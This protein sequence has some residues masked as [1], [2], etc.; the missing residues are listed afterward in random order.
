MAEH[1]REI[2]LNASKAANELS[3]FQHQLGEMPFSQLRQQYTQLRPGNGDGDVLA[4]AAP[5]ERSAAEAG[6]KPGETP[7]VSSSMRPA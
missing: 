7:D 2:D 3:G 5:V 4:Q 6:Q 1:G